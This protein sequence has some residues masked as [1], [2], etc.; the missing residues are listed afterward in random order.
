LPHRGKI[1]DAGCG[2]GR[3][4]LYFKKQGF[5]V[6]AFDA[7]AELVRLSSHLLEQQVFQLSFNEVCFRNEFEGVWACASM[8]HVPK[9]DMPTTLGKLINSLKEEG[10]LYA[11]FKYGASEDMRGNRFFNS[12]D[13]TS[14]SSLLEGIPNLSVV[15][16]WIS[17]DLRK[18]RPNEYWL[19]VLLRKEG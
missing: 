6:T 5:K 4:S 18:D 3:D 15:K 13:E 12:Y 11:S 9:T 2:S 1:L 7:S 14:F 8:L 16:M 10:I 17:E 19:N